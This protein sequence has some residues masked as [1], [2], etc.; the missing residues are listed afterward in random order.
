MGPLWCGMISLLQSIGEQISNL[1]SAQKI[2]EFLSSLEFCAG[3]IVFQ[4]PIFCDYRYPPWKRDWLLPLDRLFWRLKTVLG[5]ICLCLKTQE[6]FQIEHHIQVYA[7]QDI[8]K[9][10]NVGSLIAIIIVWVTLNTWRRPAP[11][12][13]GVNPSKGRA[14]FSIACLILQYH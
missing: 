1:C 8:G 14:A 7:V 6:K 9:P 5:C 3:G 4:N 13:S 10:C 11:T 2:Q 12:S